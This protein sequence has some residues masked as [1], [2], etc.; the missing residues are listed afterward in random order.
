MINQEDWYQSISR[1]RTAEMFVIH[2][3]D[4]QSPHGQSSVGVCGLTHINWKDRHAEVS[5][6]IGNPEYRHKGVAT[7]SLGRLAEIAF[8]EYG[9]YRLWAEIY[10]FNE[11]GIALFRKCGYRW[12]GT[13]RSAVWHDGKW[14]DSHSYSLLGP[15]WVLL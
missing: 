15:D 5:I 7:W 2:A 12:E 1:D 6:Y 4:S 11:A 8:L 3:T 14:W 13:A 9:L 10:D